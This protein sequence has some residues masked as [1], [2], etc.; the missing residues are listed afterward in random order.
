MP[1]VTGSG[2]CGASPGSG[3][4]RRDVQEFVARGQRLV[5]G[6]RPTG[7]EALAWHIQAYFLGDFAATAAAVLRE[8]APH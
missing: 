1:E 5:D 2:R 3:G 4:S 8:R 7:D 6:P